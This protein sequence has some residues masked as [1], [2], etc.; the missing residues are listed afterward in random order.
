MN[1]LTGIAVYVV[2]WWLVLFTVLPWGVRPAEELPPGADRGAPER[3][4]M[5]LKVAI[6]TLIAAVLWIGVE[7]LVRSDLIS[8]RPPE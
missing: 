7:L 8:F 1:W 4:R 5:G 3:H 2:L 6:T